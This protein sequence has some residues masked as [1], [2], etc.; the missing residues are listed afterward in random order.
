MNLC[1][2]IPFVVALL[3]PLPAWAANVQVLKAP[4]GETVWYVED[5]TLPMIAMAAA[6]PAGS[7]YDPAG[8]EGLSAFAGAMLDEG[9][10]NLNSKAYHEALSDRAIR[11]SVNPGRDYT[12]VSLV[13]LAEN[14]PEAFRLL[15][16]A[17]AHPRF[18]NDAIQR[19]RSQIVTDIRGNQEQPEV[20]AQQAF[21]QTFFAGHPYAHPEEGTEGSINRITRNDLFAF[22]HAHWVK[23]GLKIAVAGDVNAA[24]LQRLL[25]TAFGSIPSSA[26]PAI[27]PLHRMGSPGI[28][29]LAMPVP[30]S[31]AVFGLPAI[32]RSDKQFLAAYVANNILGD[33][34][35]SSRLMDEIREKRGLTY[36]VSSSLAS[37]R[38]GGFMAGSVATRREAMGQTLDVLKA[39]IKNF[40][41]NGPTAQELQDAKTYL[42]GSFPLA[43]D[44]NAGIA[45]QLSTFQTQDL[46]ADY[47][48]KR[49]DMINALTLDDVKRAAKRIFSSKITIV[50]AGSIPRGGLKPPAAPAHH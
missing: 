18:D 6:F 3:A 16:L 35:F 2:V 17:L 12:V 38:G 32:P 24:T 49:N 10:G 5:H 23:G 46:P 13:T 28:K 19:V 26:P 43:F 21:Y 11:L 39:T 31:T 1:R 42:T 4:P 7:A 20:V 9:A 50:V 47:V 22:S 37:Y 15:G 33:G 44:S 36:D 14:A 27:P 8:K 40:A 25:N 30:Q 48:S 34:G 41:A 29:V 45:G